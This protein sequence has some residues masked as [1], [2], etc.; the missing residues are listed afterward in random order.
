MLSSSRIGVRDLRK[1]EPLAAFTI[2]S[3]HV[4]E[5]DSRYGA[6]WKMDGSCMDSAWPYPLPPLPPYPGRGGR[7][8]SIRLTRMELQVCVA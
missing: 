1:Q 6:G 4:L 3:N 8:D 7:M 5:G 2:S